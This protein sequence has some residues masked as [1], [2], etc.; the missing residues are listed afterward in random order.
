MPSASGTT[1]ISSLWVVAPTGS[2]RL[3]KRSRG[4]ILGGT[5][6]FLSTSSALVTAGKRRA[7]SEYSWSG[8]TTP[9]TIRKMPRG[10]IQLSWSINSR[11]GSRLDLP[12]PP[13]V[14]VGNGAVD[15]ALPMPTPVGTTPRTITI[16][17]PIVRPISLPA[18]LAVL[19]P[20]VRR[21]GDRPGLGQRRWDAS[22]RCSLIDSPLRGVPPVMR[23]T[24]RA[25]RA[26]TRSRARGRPGAPAR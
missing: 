21:E 11:R 16:T 2:D 4:R 20:L 8:A 17:R 24:P 1:A 22:W 25:G 13:G 23:S 6:S 9:S 10:P 26:A 12:G 19:R 18:G 15:C 7:C 5:P 14:T 3:A